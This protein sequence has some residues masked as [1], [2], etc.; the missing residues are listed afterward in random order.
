MSNGKIIAAVAAGT[1]CLGI[2][3][4]VACG[5]LLY[6]GYRTASTSVGPEIDRM[7]AAI[8]NG[9]FVQTYETATTQEFRKVTSKDQYADIGK[10]VSARLGRLESKSLKS[11]NMRQ[12]NAD[13]YV[14]VIYDARFEK[15]NGQIVAKMKR[16]NGRLKIVSFRVTSPAFQQDLATAKCP[17]CGAPHAASARFCPSCGAPLFGE[18]NKTAEKAPAEAP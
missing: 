15:D 17:K 4:I 18:S 11:F 13:S 1:G 2:V 6:M 10:A 12:H 8:D 7:F 3:A 14:D 16:E 9:A 5:G